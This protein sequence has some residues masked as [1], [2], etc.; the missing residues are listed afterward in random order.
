MKNG[1]MLHYIKVLLWTPAECMQRGTIKSRKKQKIDVLLLFSNSAA[2]QR[3]WKFEKCNFLFVKMQQPFKQEFQLWFVIEKSNNISAVSANMS[4]WCYFH[5]VHY[6][7]NK[8]L[9]FVGKQHF[10][11]DIAI[12]S[13]VHVLPCF[14]SYVGGTHG[15]CHYSLSDGNF[16]F[17]L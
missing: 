5:P 16:Q 10:N 11:S 15:G 7:S 9:M 1:A 2:S 4:T 12:L 14:W 8:L 3:F 13:V 6:P 17:T